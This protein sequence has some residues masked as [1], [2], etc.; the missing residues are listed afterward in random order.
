LF[1]DFFDQGVKP[2]SDNTEGEKKKKDEEKSDVSSE[3]I[4]EGFFDDPKQD[5]KVLILF[6]W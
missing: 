1:S 2:P 4:P 5:A 6:C 3:K